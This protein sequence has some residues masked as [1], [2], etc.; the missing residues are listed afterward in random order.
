MPLSPSRNSPAL[1]LAGIGGPGNNGGSAVTVTV[2]GQSL[3]HAQIFIF[4]QA[5]RVTRQRCS[6]TQHQQQW[7]L[8]LKPRPQSRRWS[9]SSFCTR[10]PRRSPLPHLPPAKIL[11]SSPTTNQPGNLS[12]QPK[13]CCRRWPSGFRA[14]ALLS[15][16]HGR[17]WTWEE[18]RRNYDHT[19]EPWERITRPAL[20]RQWILSHAFAKPWAPEYVLGAIAAT[21][22]GAGLYPTSWVSGPRNVCGK[23]FTAA[24]ENG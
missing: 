6:C 8:Q 23:S 3:F 14:P 15:K 9:W 20:Q 13:R 1:Q 17:S 24:S 16:H 5:N 22:N 4:N 11:N 12:Q 2:G 18:A 7:R 19:C 10:H 21:A